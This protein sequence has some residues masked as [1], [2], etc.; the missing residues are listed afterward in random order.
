MKNLTLFN[1]A[2][3]LDNEEV[4]TA[5][6]VAAREDANPEVISVALADVEKALAA[7]GNT[8]RP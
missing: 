7:T 3:Y 8:T 6:L 1:A 4:I 5:Y 2:D